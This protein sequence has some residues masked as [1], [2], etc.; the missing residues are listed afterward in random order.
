[1]ATVTELPENPLPLGRPQ[2]RSAPAVRIVRWLRA[3][4]HPQP[5]GQLSIQYTHKDGTPY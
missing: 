1:M 4:P 3:N 2:Y 5:L